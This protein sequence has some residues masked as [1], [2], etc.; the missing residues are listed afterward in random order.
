MRFERF[1]ALLISGQLFAASLQLGEQV[2]EFSLKAKR[3]VMFEKRAHLLIEARSRPR[4]NQT[5]RIALAHALCFKGTDFA[6]E[7]GGRMAAC[8]TRQGPAHG[9]VAGADVLEVLLGFVGVQPF[10]L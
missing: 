4:F 7:N 8:V 5:S 2:L 3:A 1:G 10:G 6:S 9:R